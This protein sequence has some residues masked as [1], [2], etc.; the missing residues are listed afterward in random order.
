MNCL[1]DLM[2]LITNHWRNMRFTL[3]WTADKP[4]SWGF[5]S[6]PLCRSCLFRLARALARLE[7][8]A[9]ACWGNIII[10]STPQCSAN[11]IK[12]RKLQASHSYLDLDDP[13][14]EAASRFPPDILKT[15]P[16]N[17]EPLRPILQLVS[18][19][20]SN[21]HVS[22]TEKVSI[23]EYRCRRRTSFVFWQHK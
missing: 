2:L 9:W 18:D 3:T 20:L 5:H 16:E 11:I 12:K 17:L 1:I 7:Q 19:A 22:S 23:Q 4:E 14:V 21:K 10:A 6:G 15:L 8:R 13:E